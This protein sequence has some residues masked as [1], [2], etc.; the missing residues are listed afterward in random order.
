G[1]RGEAGHAKIDYARVLLERDA[2]GDRE[3][4]LRLVAE[5]GETADELGLHRL[6]ERVASLGAAP[7]LPATVT[8]PATAQLAVFRRTGDEWEI[9]IGPQTMRLKDARGLQYLARLLREPRRELHALDLGSGAVAG[10]DS[11]E[12]VDTGHAGELL[13]ASART[14]YRR[15]LTDL[16]NELEEAERFNDPGRA[17]RARAEMEFLSTE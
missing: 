11:S 2:S 13:D 3:L 6:R 8:P 10:E 9:G 1:V 16:Q 17:S 15:R 5:A 12:V 4:A 7:R 14:A